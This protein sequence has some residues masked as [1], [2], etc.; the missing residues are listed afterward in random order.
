MF[1]FFKVKLLLLYLLPYSDRK[2]IFS[3]FSSFLFF[4]LSSLSFFSLFLSSSLCPHAI[5][6][7]LFLSLIVLHFSTVTNWDFFLSYESQSTCLEYHSVCP[8]VGTGTPPPPLLQASVPPRNQRGRVHTRQRV[9]G[10]GSPN[11]DDWSKSLA[12][13]LLC[14]TSVRFESENK[15]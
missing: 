9:R 7:S 12:L 11:S 6:L 13:C 3:I 14:D 15:I 1:A 10:W 2:T 8:L 4:F 5:F